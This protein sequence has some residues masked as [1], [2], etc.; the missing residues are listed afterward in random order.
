MN[1]LPYDLAFCHRYNLYKLLGC[2][3]AENDLYS[4]SRMYDVELHELRIAEDNIQKRI[5]I[6]AQEISQELPDIC[7]A[8]S[9]CKKIYLALGDS[10]TSDRAGYVNIIRALW[11]K[12]NILDAGIS[13]NTTADVFN[14]FYRDVVK[15]PFD[16]ASIFI[17][18]NDA[19]GLDDGQGITRIGIEEFS[20][21]LSYFM[22]VMRYPPVLSSNG[23]QKRKERKV[24]AIT[25]PPVN[26]ESLRAFTGIESNYIHDN[27]HIKYMN[28]I[29]RS[30]AEQTGSI[31][32]DLAG[33]I[34]SSGMYPLEKDGL[35]LNLPAQ[36]LLAKLVIKHIVAPQEANELRW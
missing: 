34:E 13:G 7:V 2:R 23:P 17:G 8:L 28:D 31:L 12:A 20:K 6:A 24:L 22:Q 10:L 25:L 27:D 30:I 15:H 18:T 29:I 19:R 32:I 4:L 9:G 14:R 36:T 26:N 3:I 5:N 35:H 1:K 21:K 11:N 16:I 33:E